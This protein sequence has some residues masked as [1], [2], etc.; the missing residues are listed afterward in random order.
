MTTE[1]SLT[2]SVASDASA[3]LKFGKGNA[4]L[5]KEITTFS[6]PAG[7]TCPGASQCLAKANRDTGRIDDGKLQAFRCFAASAEAAYTNVR[8]SRW[9]N[10]D[11]LKGKTREEMRDLILSSLPEEASIV[12]VHV[13]GDFFS[14]GY[15]LA[16]ADVS[17]E[18]PKVKFY[19]Y[20]KSIHI[21]EKVVSQVP[22]NLVLTA[23]EGGKF[24]DRINGFKR[25][26]VVFSEDEAS[27][28]GLQI[29][30]D[31]S[32]AYDGNESFALLLH[33]TQAKGT[34][35]AKALSALKHAGK[36]GY[37]RK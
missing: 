25:A 14:E 11:L 34:I 23:S 24:D 13:S 3:K 2:T 28:L 36:G 17:K 8:E 21:W 6:L 18:R 33:G 35:A 22:S 31:D 20:T 16:W 10:F 9:H 29:D 5:G 12:R 7:W 30:H 4:K 15:F 19:A 26:K 1:K 27:A 32:H 37:S